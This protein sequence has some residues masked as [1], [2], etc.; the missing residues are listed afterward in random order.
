MLNKTIIFSIWTLLAL[1]TLTLNDAH[2]LPSGTDSNESSEEV[3]SIS[4]A[5]NIADTDP[6]NEVVV[7]AADSVVAAETVDAMLVAQAED[8]SG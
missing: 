5:A 4:D 2:A 6:V 1:M 8:S 7:A 3:G